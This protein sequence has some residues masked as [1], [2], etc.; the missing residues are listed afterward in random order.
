MLL[1]PLLFN[2]RLV[3]LGKFFILLADADTHSFWNI[4][5]HEIG[6]KLLFIF[7]A[8]SSLP[9]LELEV[10]LLRMVVYWLLVGQRAQVGVGDLR[11]DKELFLIIS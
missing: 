5:L 10:F 1:L 2:V 3:I 6:V 8:D 9:F 4:R 11:E 7:L